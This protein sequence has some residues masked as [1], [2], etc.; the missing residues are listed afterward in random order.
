MISQTLLP[1]IKMIERVRMLCQQDERLVAALMYGSFTRGEGDQFSDIEFALFFAD[2]QLPLIDQQAWVAQIA[3]LA[4]YFSDDVGHQTAIFSNLVRS[5]FHFEAASAM[6]I[7]ETWRGNAWFPDLESAVLVDRTGALAQHLQPL[8]GPAP[9]RDTAEVAQFLTN[10]F[11]NWILFG[12]NVL[13]RGE[14]ARTLEILGI[15]QRYLLWMV[16]LVEGTTAQWP[17]PSKNVEQAISTQSYARYQQCT[18]NLERA[19]LM[20][21]YAATWAWGQEMIETLTQRHQTAR[22][23]ALLNQLTERLAVTFYDR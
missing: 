15:I 22:P 21:A 19:T 10:N 17:T 14:L 5:E 4:L 23:A 8:I 12:T 9:V 1:Q 3:P 2:E 18:A 20:R 11:I 7:V 13:A 6:A 16:R